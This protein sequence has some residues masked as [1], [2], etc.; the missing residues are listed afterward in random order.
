MY[1]ENQVFKSSFIYL[2]VVKLNHK[3]RPGLLKLLLVS[4]KLF[5]A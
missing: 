2:G 3:Y 4:E 5:L 1:V